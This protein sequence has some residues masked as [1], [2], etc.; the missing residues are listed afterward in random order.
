MF[1]RPLAILQRGPVIL[2]GSLPRA[3]EV[4][5]ECRVPSS[6]SNQMRDRHPYPG[7]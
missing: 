3:N 1:N 4:L 2:T 6:V 5:A 7:P